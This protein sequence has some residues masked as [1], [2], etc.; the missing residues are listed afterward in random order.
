M[1]QALQLKGRGCALGCVKGLAPLRQ[2]CPVKHLH[3]LCASVAVCHASLQ[4]SRFALI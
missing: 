2:L 4:L 3:K 1:L